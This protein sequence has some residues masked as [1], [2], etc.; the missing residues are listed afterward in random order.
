ME[1]WTG[2]TA[3][4]PVIARLER[5]ILFEKK[6]VISI[7]TSVHD[8][9]LYV[10]K[11]ALALMMSQLTAFASNVSSLRPCRIVFSVRKPFLDAAIASLYEGMSVRH[12]VGSL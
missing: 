4:T 10:T 8:A 9:G 7:A 6:Y 2:K 3:L 5:T 1:I 11:F 12:F